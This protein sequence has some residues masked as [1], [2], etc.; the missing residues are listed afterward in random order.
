MLTKLIREH[1]KL[2]EETLEQLTLDNAQLKQT[3]AVQET[4]HANV[5]Q[6]M[7][8]VNAEQK[9]AHAKNVQDMMQMAAEVQSATTS[10]YVLEVADE[11]T[12]AYL[13]KKKQERETKKASKRAKKKKQQQNMLLSS[14]APPNIN[15]DTSYYQQQIP[16]NLSARD[17]NMPTASMIVQQ[18]KDLF[19]PPQ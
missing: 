12:L 4:A 13:T 17:Q 3:N 11:K 7:M 2:T 16:A 9:T 19:P 6:D 5:L 8:Q 14:A 1:D 15:G 18:R 10:N